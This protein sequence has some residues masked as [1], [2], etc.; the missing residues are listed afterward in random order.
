MV[1]N[2]TQYKL[3][4]KKV[5][6]GGEKSLVQCNRCVSEGNCHIA[7]ITFIFKLHETY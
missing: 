4:K 2:I 1:T 3:K 5:L 7:L 6:M